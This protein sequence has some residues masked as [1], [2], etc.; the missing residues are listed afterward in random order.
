[1]TDSDDL[2]AWRLAGLLEERLT[3]TAFT[4]TLRGVVLREKVAKSA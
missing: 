2:T 4:N 3:S 1:M